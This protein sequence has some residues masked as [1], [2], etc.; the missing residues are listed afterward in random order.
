MGGDH[1]RTPRVRLRRWIL[2]A[3]RAG[4]VERRFRR[5]VR[6]LVARITVDIAGVR[7]RGRNYTATGTA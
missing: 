5:L 7:S 2:N 6:L 4:L 1:I 3:R